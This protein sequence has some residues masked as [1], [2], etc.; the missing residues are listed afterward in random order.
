M[1]PLRVNKTYPSTDMAAKQQRITIDNFQGINVGTAPHLIEPT[2]VLDSIGT[3]FI[4]GEIHGIPPLCLLHETGGADAD[5]SANLDEYEHTSLFQKVYTSVIT[6]GRFSGQGFLLVTESRSSMVI[7][8]PDTLSDTKIIPVYKTNQPSTQTDRSHMCLITGFD[9]DGLANPITTSGYLYVKKG[10]TANSFI[11]STDNQATWSGDQTIN[12]TSGTN[13]TFGGKTLTVW[14]KTDDLTSIGSQTWVWRSYTSGNAYSITDDAFTLRKSSYCQIGD[15]FVFTHF[16]H[17]MCHDGKGIYSLG[18]ERMFGHTVR[19]F[20]NHLVILGS[21]FLGFKGYSAFTNNKYA[22]FMQYS[23]LDSPHEFEGTNNNEADEYFFPVEPNSHTMHFG[24]KSGEIWNDSLY[25]FTSINTYKVDYVGLPLVMVVTDLGPITSCLDVGSTCVT[26]KGIALINSSGKL[27]LFNGQT[28]TDIGDK[29]MQITND[30]RANTLSA[31]APLGS[32]FFANTAAFYN[33]ASSLVYDFA[34]NSIVW[35]SM[36][37]KYNDYA[38]FYRHSYSFDN[39]YSYRLLFTD[40]ATSDPD[41]IADFTSALK[42][43]VRLW[44][45]KGKLYGINSTATAE[46]SSTPRDIII[47]TGDLLINNLQDFVTVENVLPA[48]SGLNNSKDLCTL[49]YS[50]RDKLGDDV[51]YTRAGTVY[52]GQTKPIVIHKRGKIWRFKLIFSNS[53]TDTDALQAV[54]LHNIVFNVTGLEQNVEA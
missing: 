6:T 7:V 39:G 16:G 15:L 19:N 45:Y 35:A 48:V 37:I 11:Y 5:Y 28:E 47:E 3:E 2:E 13:I 31:N 18:Y 23:H 12:L 52:E 34:N 54:K 43:N 53:G 42:N 46:D 27:V 33:G 24:V 4:D 36:D 14:F 17:V 8:N 22:F 30:F 50:H 26:P 21:S 9:K 29:F 25:V 20:F 44:A 40:E 51:V 10:S 38:R 41:V 32:P 1:N 49:Y